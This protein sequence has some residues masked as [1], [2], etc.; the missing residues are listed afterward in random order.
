MIDN[1]SPSLNNSIIEISTRKT[2]NPDFI[3]H[4]CTVSNNYGYGITLQSLH[5]PALVLISNCLIRRN[6]QWGLFIH[7]GISATVDCC[8]VLSNIC[9]GV[10]IGLN[11][12]SSV[13]LKNNSIC[14][15]FGFA[16]FS[17]FHDAPRHSFLSQHYLEALQSYNNKV[18][19]QNSNDLM[20]P[21]VPFTAPPFVSE[22]KCFSNVS[23]YS[24]KL[25]QQ[26]FDLD[27]AISFVMDQQ[28]I[29]PN[30][31]ENILNMDVSDETFNSVFFPTDRCSNCQ[32]KIINPVCCNK[33]S[34]VYC[35]EECKIEHNPYHSLVCSSCENFP[36]EI[37]DSKKVQKIVFT[38]SKPTDVEELNLQEKFL[39]YSGNFLV[40]LETT[41]DA[42]GNPVLRI[43]IPRIQN[44]DLLKGTSQEISFTSTQ[45]K[46]YQWVMVFGNLDIMNLA[47][48][49]ALCKASWDSSIYENSPERKRI[50]VG[51]I[52]DVTSAEEF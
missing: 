4:R 24:R 34:L 39:L 8:S 18:K 14:Y 37:V 25:L 45:S 3:F 44:Q 48:K 46:L 7:D 19:E 40:R 22:N 35:C 6:G 15:N 43:C 12:D 50:K 28:L 49:T 41:E 26:W 30:D 36:F 20:K 51:L 29:R 13:I 31:F 21:P 38:I 11:Y 32:G 16:I 9:G 2:R 47:S 23:R 27:P 42:E 1:E 33:C 10:R 52:I 17:D 5:S